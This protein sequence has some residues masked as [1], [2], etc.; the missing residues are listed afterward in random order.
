MRRLT[1]ILIIVCFSTSQLFGREGLARFS[2]TP[3]APSKEAVVESNLPPI[4]E[5][6]KRESD[7]EDLIDNLDEEPY[8]DSIITPPE[9]TGNQRQEEDTTDR[10][11][12]GWFIVISFLLFM[13]GYLITKSD[14]GG[15]TFQCEDND[16]IGI[17]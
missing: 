11:L 13:A 7:D 3:I 6:S 1:T 9:N 2:Q 15:L 5:E 10:F 14:R 17:K 12:R 16:R 4:I 8:I